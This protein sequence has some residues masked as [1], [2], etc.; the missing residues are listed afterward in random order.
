M[1][2]FVVVAKI[3]DLAPGEGRVVDVNGNEVAL[4]NLDGAYYAIDNICV[5]RGGPLGEGLV[6][7]EVVICPWHDWRYNIKT[8]VSPTN[9]AIKVKIYNVKVENGE[10]KVSL[11]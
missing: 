7:G 5:H 10:V 8:G 3:Q 1:S 2:E 9:P 6:E 11:T 4:F